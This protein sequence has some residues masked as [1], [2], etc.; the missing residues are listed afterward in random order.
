MIKACRSKLK[1]HK[2]QKQC[3]KVTTVLSYITY[4]HT[5]KDTTY[6]VSADAYTVPLQA[7]TA[8][9]TKNTFATHD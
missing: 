2:F 7:L 9:H 1:R 3:S 8:S 5:Y 4:G 6:R